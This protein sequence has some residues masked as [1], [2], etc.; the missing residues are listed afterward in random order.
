MSETKLLKT[1]LETKWSVWFL[2]PYLSVEVQIWLQCMWV[3]LEIKLVNVLDDIHWH[4]LVFC[5][6]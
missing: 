2:F 3:I 6:S 5:D 1:K 4:C